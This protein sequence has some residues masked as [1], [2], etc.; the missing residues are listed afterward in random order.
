M[1]AEKK[2]REE[3]DSVKASHVWVV[4]LRTGSLILQ[5]S[6]SNAFRQGLTVVSGSGL[7]G[8]LALIQKTLDCGPSI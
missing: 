5:H 8:Q 4:F 6:H 7:S 3:G 1:K 2:E